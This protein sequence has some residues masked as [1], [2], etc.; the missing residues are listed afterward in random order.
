[1]WRAMGFRTQMTKHFFSSGCG[2]VSR[3]A[4]EKPRQH[5][6][7]CHISRQPECHARA[8]TA[9]KSDIR[10][11]AAASRTTVWQSECQRKGSSRGSSSSGNR[12]TV[13]SN[14]AG[15]PHAART[16]SQGS[17]QSDGHASTAATKAAIATRMPTSSWPVGF[18]RVLFK[19]F[20]WNMFIS[21]Q[22]ASISFS[23]S[24]SFSLFLFHSHFSFFIFIFMSFQGTA[25][26]EE[27]CAA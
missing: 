11:R 22:L 25:H 5:A 18:A 17:R 14:R 21:L 7:P 8:E 26:C 2:C 10:R 24:F 12:S 27:S 6:S 15:H 1:M 20:N 23:V 3:A 16:C 9:P 19:S 13:R 4:K